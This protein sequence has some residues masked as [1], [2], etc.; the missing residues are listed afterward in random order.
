MYEQQYRILFENSRDSYLFVWTSY[1]VVI[2]DA[3]VETYSAIILITLSMFSALCHAVN[4]I[5][6]AGTILS[7]SLDTGRPVQTWYIWALSS[8]FSHQS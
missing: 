2:D 5:G 3:D 1:L 4:S 7:V 6:I 8:Y